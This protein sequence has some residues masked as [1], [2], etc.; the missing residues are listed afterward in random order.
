MADVKI[1]ELPSGTAGSTDEMPVNQ[2]G[3]TRKITAQGVADLKTWSNLSGKVGYAL[4]IL[5]PN[6]ATTTDAQNLHFGGLSGLAPD[7]NASLARIY[8]PKAGTVTI[9]YVTAYSGTA[10]TNESW[11]M[12]IRLNNTA[13]TLI[14][15][16]SSTANLRVWSNTSL[17][18]SVAQGDWVEIKSVNP[19]W[20]TNPANVRFGGVI[21]VE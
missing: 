18:I 10:G 21:Y 8:I 5:A 17:S 12:Y 7:P 14:Q 11:S 20:A 19:T 4:N 9:V 1:S 15:A 3:T 2:S 16:L 13:D 6:V